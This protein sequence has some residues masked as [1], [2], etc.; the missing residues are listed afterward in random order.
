MPDHQPLAILNSFEVAKE[1]PLCQTCNATLN[2]KLVSSESIH[3]IDL[4]TVLTCLELAQNKQTIPI[5]DIKWWN[6]I[7][8]EH[9]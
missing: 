2:F 4:N 5:L 7:R 3:T 1:Q 8:S 9:G 6:R